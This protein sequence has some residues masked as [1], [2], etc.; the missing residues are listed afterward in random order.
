M[1]LSLSCSRASNIGRNFR[2]SLLGLPLSSTFASPSKKDVS[3][4]TSF[5]CFPLYLEVPIRFKCA[6]NLSGINTSGVAIC[7]LSILVVY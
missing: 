7:N 1:L 4:I 6:C 5:R 3:R 2:K